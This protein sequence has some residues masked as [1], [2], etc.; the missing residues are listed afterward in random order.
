MI[1]DRGSGS[2]DRKLVRDLVYYRNLGRDS[3]GGNTLGRDPG[4][5]CNL[6]PNPSVQNCIRKTNFE[7]FSDP[8]TRFGAKI[9][10]KTRSYRP[11]LHPKDEFRDF[12]RA[13][14]RLSDLSGPDLGPK[15]GLKHAVIVQNFIRK[16]NFEIFSEPDFVFRT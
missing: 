14:F 13:R 12:F 11:E 2:C 15:S 6:R 1:Q 9:R 5:D 4:C 7:I 8:G 3:Y 16:T 10:P